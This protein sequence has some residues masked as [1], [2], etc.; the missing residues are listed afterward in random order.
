MSRDPRLLSNAY[1]LRACE[2]VVNAL[3]EQPVPFVVRLHT[4]A[5]SRPCVVYPGRLGFV[6][7]NE[8]STLNSAARSLEEFKVLPN[9]TIVLNV[10]PKG[11]L[12]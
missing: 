4:E 6:D 5:P 9:L 12:G 11:G 10:G 8:P 3:Q 1:Y 2:A 7:V